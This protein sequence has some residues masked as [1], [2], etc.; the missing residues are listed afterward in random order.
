MWEKLTKTSVWVLSKKAG[1]YSVFSLKT[2]SWFIS[3]PKFNE[4]D[5][6]QN[7]KKNKQKKVLFI[8]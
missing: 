6:I 8:L 7:I 5:G 1:I 2:V 3:K 4:K